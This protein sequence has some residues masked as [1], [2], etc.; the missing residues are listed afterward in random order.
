MLPLAEDNERG[1]R[2][3]RQQE[4]R[5]GSNLVENRDLDGAFLN[6]LQVG[7]SEFLVKISFVDH[8]LNSDFPLG[9]L[10]QNNIPEVSSPRWQ[11]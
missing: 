8:P 4:R 5:K 1:R 3:R 9:K 11:H 7:N 2:V 6:K 10:E